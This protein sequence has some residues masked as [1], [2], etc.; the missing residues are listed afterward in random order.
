MRLGNK[1]THVQHGGAHK[2]LPM[3]LILDNT[4]RTGSDIT[5]VVEYIVTQRLVLAMPYSG[6]IP[7]EYVVNV[8]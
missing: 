1:Y 8:T 4:T 6:S 2:S 7:K 3:G 5:Q